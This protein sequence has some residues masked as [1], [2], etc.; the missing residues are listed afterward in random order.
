MACNPIKKVPWS[1]AL[2][3]PPLTKPRPC[4]HT[5]STD[6]PGWLCRSLPGTRIMLGQSSAWGR[7]DCGKGTAQAESWHQSGRQDCRLPEEDGGR[8]SMQGR[9]GMRGNLGIVNVCDSLRK[10]PRT[11]DTL[12]KS[13]K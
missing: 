12:P 11:G 5:L 7:R 6:S 9:W 10:E 1:G 3:Q 4:T 13:C 2:H 8:W